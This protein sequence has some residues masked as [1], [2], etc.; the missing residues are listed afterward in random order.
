MSVD[1]F[2]PEIWSQELRAAY[3]KALVFVSLCNR[4]YEGEI[5]KAGDTVH[6]NTIGDPTVA[7]YVAG[8][9]QITA[10]Q[11]ATTDQTL[12]IN[13]SKYFA[14]KVDDVDKRQA[15]GAVLTK[16]MERSA[17]KMKDA[18]DQYIA[19]LYTGADAANVID[20]VHIDTGDAAYEQLIN[21]GVL[22]DQANVPEEG[23]NAVAPPWFFGLLVTS[24]YATNA[25]FQAANAAIQS[26]KVGEI[27]GFMLHKSN[28]VKV[29]TGD[30]YAVTAL[31]QDAISFAD[32]INETEALR[33]EKE[34]AD[35]VRGLHLYG[36]KVVEP[37]ALAVLKASK[38][39]VA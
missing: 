31:T 6:I 34:F 19:G 7:D 10:E 4:D 25:A 5:A 29:I 11:L 20:T 26:G 22:L 1:T 9:T 13:Q 15:A 36:A 14:F 8:T 17:Y 24:K 39:A 3:E 27:G 2:K 38:T 33:M 35:M 37:K 18:A 32:Q 28:N 21:L 30:D 16:G 12:L 23:R